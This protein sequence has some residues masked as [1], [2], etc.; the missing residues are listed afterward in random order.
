MS[1]AWSENPLV[2]VAQTGPDGNLWICV[3]ESV[4]NCEVALKKLEDVLDK[5]SADNGTSK[6]FMRKPVKQIR[7]NMNKKEIQGFGNEI[8]TYERALTIAFNAINA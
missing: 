2:A 6:G 3:K 5:I 4:G 8:Q 7:L 1:T